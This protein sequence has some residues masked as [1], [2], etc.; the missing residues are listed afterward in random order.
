MSMTNQ[1]IVGYSWTVEDSDG[2][3]RRYTGF[4]PATTFTEDIVLVLME[5]EIE[6]WAVDGKAGHKALLGYLAI[7]W[8]GMPTQSVLYRKR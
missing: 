8:E 4:R 1:V 6:A 3:V 7:E 2:S 5:G